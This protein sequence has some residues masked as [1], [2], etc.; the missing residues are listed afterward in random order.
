M[1][2]QNNLAYAKQQDTEDKLSH[3]R[4]QFHIP[5]DKNGNDWLYFTGNSLGLQPKNTQKYIQQE[6]DDWANYGVEGHFEA[7]KPWVKYHEFLTESMA[8]IVGAKPIEV[9]VMNTLTTNLHLLMVS[10]YQPTKTK[11]KIVIESDAFPSDR[12]AVQSQLQ[13]HGFNSEEGLIEWK[14][15]KG[16]DLLN[17]DDLE[18]IVSEQGDEIALLLIGGVNYYT[19]QSLD[20]KRIA[21]IGHSKNCFVGI[22]LAHG[23]GNI[24]P[25]L[26]NSGVDFAAWC[27][28]KYLNAGPGSL[29]G[30][31]VHEKH[32]HNKELPRF[33][34]WW[35]HNKETRFNM[36]QPFDV[37]PGAE[38]WQLS[39]P[40][41]LS[42]AAIRSSL[43][44][45]DKVGMD[46]L[47]QKSEKLTG[48]F[49][50][51]INEINS[52]DIKI[53]TPSNPKERGCQLSIQVKNANK[54]L[55]KKLT[56]NNVITDWREP[57]VIRCAPVPMYNS[58]EDVYRMV[59]ILSLALS[60]GKEL[61]P[62][63]NK[64]K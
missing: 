4:D 10:F 1:T 16:E 12:Y 45:F 14:P 38:G 20:L 25:D 44:L 21:E 30:L 50:F 62:I 61:M 18:T 34:G 63:N 13:F 27:T 11:Y 2:H 23:A 41:I 40:P 49:E 55:H 37:M 24:S 28:Y 57:D 29:G 3:L 31:F 46:A 42:M 59:K 19:G 32:A 54:S 22:D 36:R 9:V 17:I 8:E 64:E 56:K 58:F 52:D 35:N 26:H 53:I 47:R 39:N 5:K 6:L 48:Y 7:K 33:S 60:E 43:D 15:R 51:L